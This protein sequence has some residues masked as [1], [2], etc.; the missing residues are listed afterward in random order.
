MH[1]AKLRVRRH[2]TTSSTH[3]NEGAIAAFFFVRA[4][5]LEALRRRTPPFVVRSLDMTGGL[6]TV[7]SETGAGVQR[8]LRA[9]GVRMTAMNLAGAH[10]DPVERV[11]A[12][13]ARLVAQKRHLLVD[14]VAGVARPR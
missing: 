10:M 1:V 9:D 6:R 13:L 5:A 2:R 11:E 4:Q 8:S 3:G 7:A 14:E 12:G